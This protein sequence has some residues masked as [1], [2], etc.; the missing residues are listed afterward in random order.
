MAG[1]ARRHYRRAAGPGGCR[2]VRVRRAHTSC[3]KPSCDS[4]LRSRIG[5]PYVELDAVLDQDGLLTLL[6]GPRLPER[7]CRARSRFAADGTEVELAFTVNEGPQI[8]IGRITVLGNE[9]VSEQQILE[10]LRLVPGQ[11]MSMAVAHD[12]P[13]AARRHGGVSQF[14]RRGRRSAQ[15]R[16]RGPRRRHGRRSAGDDDRIRSWSRGR[17]PREAGRGRARRSTTWWR[18]RRADSSR[19]AGVILADAIA[20]STCSPASACAGAIAR[21]CP[22]PSRRHEFTE[23][24][25]TGTFREQHAF[26]SDTDLLVSFTSE[27]AVRPTYNYVRHAA[28]AEFLRRLTRALNVFGTV[29]ARLH[30]TVRRADSRRGSAADRSAVPAGPAVI[31]SRAG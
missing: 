27:Q 14:Q 10:E 20:P 13:S 16:D 9:R 21:I 25:V 29:H 3:R 22:R 11:P 6:P 7:R 23:Y 19:S 12:R 24:R 28:N 15:R 4:R 30:P 1:P 2:D 8:T 31:S 17:Q 26:R 5:A 18:W